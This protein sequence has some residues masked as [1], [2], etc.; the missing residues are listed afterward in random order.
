MYQTAVNERQMLKV[1]NQVAE[2]KLE[3]KE[4]KVVKLE[5][6]LATSRQK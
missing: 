5:K 6:M 1:D 2:R 4:E 3:R